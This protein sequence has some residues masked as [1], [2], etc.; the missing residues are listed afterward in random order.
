MDIIKM[1]TEQTTLEYWKE[2]GNNQSIHNNT[3]IVNRMNLN[4]ALKRAFEPIIDGDVE[5]TDNGLVATNYT[6][7][8]R[9]QY[10]SLWDLMVEDW[11]GVM[12]NPFVLLI[13]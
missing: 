2:L 13:G 9:R 1:A 5:W 4:N 10:D 12:D 6:D 3:V 8:Y 7:Y 11:M